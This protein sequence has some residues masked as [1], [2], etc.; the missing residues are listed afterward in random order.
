MSIGLR[1]SILFAALA[2]FSSAFLFPARAQDI[3]DVAVTTEVNAMIDVGAP[4]PPLRVL[5]EKAVQAKKAMIEERK[6]FKGEVGQ[7]MNEAQE[8]REGMRDD[9]Q[10]FRKNVL[11]ERKQLHGDVLAKFQA[12]TTP[13]EKQA[14]LKDARKARADFRLEV[15]ADAETMRAGCKEQRA[16]IK[17]DRR[18]R[19]ADRFSMM[20][21]RMTNALEHFDQI[22]GRIDTRIEK[23]KTENVDVTAAVAASAAASVKIDAASV[24]VAD[25]KAAIDAAAASETP[26]DLA[27][28]VR[29]KVDAART[30]IKEAHEALK[31]AVA[32][33]KSL[34]GL[35]AETETTVEAN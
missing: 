35:K 27:A 19:L 15:K 21:R 20:L 12:A 1:F 16:D 34:S 29:A 3:V 13:E 25:A 9:R 26:K 5:R 23:L 10:E 24:A 4:K 6:A 18:A 2:L 33:L 8:T 17:D 31:D 11:T 32:E 28:E 22:L 7:F 14:I 30:A